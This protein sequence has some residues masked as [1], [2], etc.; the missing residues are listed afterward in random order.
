MLLLILLLML[1]AAA[2]AQEP[3]SQSNPFG[4]VYPPRIYTTMRLTGPAP[5]IDGRLDDL[6]WQQGEWAGDYIQ[7]IPVEGKAGMRGIRASM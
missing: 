5:E 2:A 4:R 6:A 1:P 3:T 7:Q